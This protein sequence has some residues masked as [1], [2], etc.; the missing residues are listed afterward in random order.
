MK[1][2]NCVEHHFAKTSVVTSFVII[3][4]FDTKIVFF[5]CDI[6]VMLCSL[7]KLKYAPGHGHGQ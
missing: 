7:S 2:V 1:Y 4:Y 3:E 6:H 5:F